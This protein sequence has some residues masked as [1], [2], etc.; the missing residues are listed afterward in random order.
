MIFES[1]GGAIAQSSQRVVLLCNRV[2]GWSYC[3]IEY[4]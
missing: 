1:A 4:L 3:V 2:S